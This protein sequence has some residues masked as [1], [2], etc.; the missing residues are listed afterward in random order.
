MGLETL[1]S[2]IFVSRG[3]R[4]DEAASIAEHLVTSNMS[5]YDSHG[6]I[7]VPQY[8]EWL[9]EGKLIANRELEIV[10]DSEALTVA[11]G[12]LGFG[13]SLARQGI[14]I[15][16]RKCRQLGISLLG[17]RNCGHLG[18]IGYWSRMAADQG[19]ISLHFVNSSGLGMFVVPAGG[20]DPRLS[21]NVISAGI[22]VEGRDPV[23]LDISAAAAAEGKLMVACNAGVEVPDDWIIDADGNPS[24]DPNKFYGPPKGAILPLG[25]HKGYGLGLIIDL[26]AGALTGGGC[27]AAGKT[28]LEQSML[29]IYIDP[30]KLEQSNF[31][32]TEIRRYLDFV[33]TSRPTRPGGKIRIPGENSN[34]LR[35]NN[36][37][38]IEIDDTT[39]RELVQTAFACGLD[40]SQTNVA[41]GNGNND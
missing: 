34:R 9:R 36:A 6:V 7:R 21:V 27:S 32:P 4:A 3:C 12:Q 33:R 40:Q 8:I 22:P 30:A 25:G 38:E 19:I 14:D 18:R 29:G 28:Q 2:Q 13:L 24:N 35:E 31:I 15:G 26:L 5:G 20:L 17:I 37:Q 10:I 41:L 11:D 16:I 1:V 23:I 39:W